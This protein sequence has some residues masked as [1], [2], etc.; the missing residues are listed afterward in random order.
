[1]GEDWDCDRCG[2]K[3]M[4]C[5]DPHNDCP[6][7]KPD[8]T[9]RERKVAKG[10]VTRFFIGLPGDDLQYTDDSG[11]TKGDLVNAF[12]QALADEVAKERERAA[13]VAEME[14]PKGMEWVGAT[15]GAAIRKGGE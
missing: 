1:M 13:R 8:P 3:G 7:K 14:C 5:G 11:L 4:N 6:A 9:E 15:I 12:A 2:K 10:V